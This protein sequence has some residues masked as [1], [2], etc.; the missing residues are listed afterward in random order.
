MPSGAAAP[1]GPEIPERSPQ[2]PE[3]PNSHTTPL[4]RPYLDTTC[5]TAHSANVPAVIDSTTVGVPAVVRF[6][7]RSSVSSVLA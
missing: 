4:P 5:A 3:N 7:L 1:A 6:K 2:S